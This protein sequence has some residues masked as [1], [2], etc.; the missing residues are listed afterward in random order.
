[1]SRPR[2]LTPDP[3]ALRGQ[4]AV[5]SVKYATY[6]KA[7]QSFGTMK[8]APVGYREYE[9]KVGSSKVESNRGFRAAKEAMGKKCDEAVI[10]GDRGVYTPEF[11]RFPH[12]IVEA[13]AALFDNVG[14]PLLGDCKKII[15]HL[16]YVEPRKLPYAITSLKGKQLVFEL[17]FNNF[18]KPGKLRFT[19]DCAPEDIVKPLSLLAP[20]TPKV[21][22]PALARSHP[23]PVQQPRH[24][25]QSSSPTRPTPSPTIPQ[26]HTIATHHSSYVAPPETPHPPQITNTNRNLLL[27]HDTPTAET[28][29]SSPPPRTLLTT[30]TRQPPHPRH[31]SI[32]VAF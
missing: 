23:R 29:T 19:V 8:D 18:N 21:E 7:K 4:D 13:K 12:K 15:K 25:P 27:L 22:I 26:R 32:R 6:E 2:S 14:I 10:S 16:G 3:T 31:I 5:R 17:Q 28:S 9:R 30:I 11:N 1:M 24:H 20:A